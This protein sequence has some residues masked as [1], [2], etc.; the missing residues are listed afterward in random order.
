MMMLT[1]SHCILKN[2]IRETGTC[3]TK[4]GSNFKCFAIS[5]SYFTSAKVFGD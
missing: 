2:F 5:A 3:L 4:S 1:R